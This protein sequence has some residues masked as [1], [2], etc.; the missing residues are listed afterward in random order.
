MHIAQLIS[1]SFIKVS[2]LVYH[3][4]C[5]QTCAYTDSQHSISIEKW[6][7]WYVCLKTA[8]S[9]QPCMRAWVRVCMHVFSAR[10]FEQCLLTLLMRPLKRTSSAFSCCTLSASSSWQPSLSCRSCTDDK[11]P[12]KTPVK[13]SNPTKMSGYCGRFNVLCFLLICSSILPHWGLFSFCGFCHL[14]LP[15]D[16]VPPPEW[17]QFKD[18]WQFMQTFYENLHT[19][20][21]TGN[22]KKKSV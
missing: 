3:I 11:Q 21:H 12:E 18:S 16:V 1:A 4:F 14:F 22:E 2:P 7:L 20:A 6:I 9:H 19:Y 17:G 10:W 13:R 8:N 15:G 5:W